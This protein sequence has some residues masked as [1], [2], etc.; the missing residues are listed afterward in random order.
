MAGATGDRGRSLSTARSPS[1]LL[2]SLGCLLLSGGLALNFLQLAQRNQ[3][4]RHPPRSR[5]RQERDPLEGTAT[6]SLGSRIESLPA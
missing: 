3:T 1:M 5:H 6:D 2:L 4:L